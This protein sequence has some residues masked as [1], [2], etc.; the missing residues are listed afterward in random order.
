MGYHPSDMSER[1]AYGLWLLPR[2]RRLT[3]L[4][5]LVAI[6]SALGLNF[7]FHPTFSTHSTAPA[8]ALPLHSR[9]RS[10]LPLFNSAYANSVLDLHPQAYWPLSDLSGA[11]ISGHHLT[12]SSM[13][14]ATLD[15]NGAL[16]NTPAL[17]FSSTG[18][19]TLPNGPALGSGTS[20][21]FWAKNSDR[22]TA[23][24]VAQYLSF[25]PGLP[26]ASLVAFAS[27]DFPPLLSPSSLQVFD[28]S[29]STA[30]LTA[31]D[32]SQPFHWWQGW[33]YFVA[34]FDPSGLRLYEDATL[35]AIGA[36]ALPLP[37]SSGAFVLANNTV[38]NSPFA[39]SLAQ[40]AVY[41]SLLTPAQ[42]TVHYAAASAGLTIEPANL[43]ASPTH[44]VY[45]SPRSFSAA[46]A[47]ISDS[48]TYTI[49]NV[50][51]LPNQG[52]LAAHCAPVHIDSKALIA[53][54]GT[55][56]GIY[57]LQVRNASGQAG[58]AELFVQPAATSFAVTPTQ[59]F[60]TPETN[61]L[62][63]SS[64]ATSNGLDVSLSDPFT[65]LTPPGVTCTTPSSSSTSW[66]V[67]CTASTVDTYPLVFIDSAH[68]RYSAL[69]Y[70]SLPSTQAA[71]SSSLLTTL[72]SLVSAI[73]H[74]LLIPDSPS[75][76]APSSAQSHL[77]SLSPP[78]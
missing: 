13:A 42:I 2:L 76:Q 60:T 78:P 45:F 48:D 9:P 3:A 47:D 50:G 58:A 71:S 30:A 49:L 15:P 72:T 36:P 14:G 68:L 64:A 74:P 75:P 1:D 34:T 52:T 56:P 29:T 5:V 38:H 6:V 17:A 7:A 31:S 73:P 22:S 11:D 61:I 43:Y 33:H 25:F 46:G 19:A 70:V 26:H 62:F 77:P 51:P 59:A 28:V 55:V 10:T 69:L 23:H 37:T 66:T 65:V 39:G 18:Y 67:S 40:V 41:S 53:C 57:Y 12:L 32:S 21:E 63:T 54:T 8:F 4:F 27:P 24:V 20:L 35:L 16:P 44:T